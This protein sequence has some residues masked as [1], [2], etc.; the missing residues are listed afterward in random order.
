MPAH[1]GSAKP[2]PLSELMPSWQLFRKIDFM[3]SFL[4]LSGS[5]LLVS[6]LNEANQHFEWSS[7]TAIT[8]VVLACLSWIVFFVWELCIVANCS[9]YDPIFPR[10]FLSNRAWIGI[11]I[12]TFASGCPWNVI[13]LYISQRLQLLVKMSPLEAGIHL[14]P[15]SAVATVASSLACLCS[16]KGRV[17]FVYTTLLGSFLQIVGVTLLS[18]LP[19]SPT[20]PTEGPGYEALAGL[21][22]GTTIGILILATPFVVEVQDLTNA[23]GALTQYR[24]LGGAIGLSVASNILNSRLKSKLTGVLSSEQLQTLL[25]NPAMVSS[26]SPD[27]QGIIEAVFSRSYTIQLRAMIAFSAMQVLAALLMFKRGRQHAVA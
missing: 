2:Q 22:I 19:E 4:Q 27:L 12:T 17:P 21:G 13:I 6:V 11:L 5:L 9:G 3:G 16:S 18:T 8:L 1:F 23:T 15:F 25:Q 24:F 7:P 20:F 14:I 26:F 10:R